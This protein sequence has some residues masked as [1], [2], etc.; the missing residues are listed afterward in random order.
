MNVN[1]CINQSHKCNWVS[2]VRTSKASKAYCIDFDT[3]SRWQLLL[4]KGIYTKMYKMYIICKH[5]YVKTE[6]F[7]VW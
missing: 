4:F 7:I 5:E 2:S 3:I 6:G 1:L